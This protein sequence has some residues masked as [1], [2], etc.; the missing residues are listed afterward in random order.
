[1]R[2]FLG[3]A[4]LIYV[5]A[6][7]PVNASENT[8]PAP[9]HSLVVKG[10]QRYGS[11]EILKAS[12][13]RTGERVG[14]A[15]FEQARQAL[16]DLQVFSS[17]SDRYHYSALPPAYDVSFEVKEIEQVFPIRFERLPVSTSQITE[18][19]KANVP[20]YTDEIPGTEAVLDRYR[21]AV[22]L[23]VAHT[24]PSLKIKAIVSNEDPK[25]LAVVFGPDTPVPVISQV[26]IT[27]NAGVDS[28]SLLRAVNSVAIGVPASDVR[29]KEIL[30]GAVKHLYAESGYMDV[31]F[32]SIETEPSKTDKGVILKL[33]INE[34]PQF[35]FGSIR[36]KGSGLEED[37]V[38]A[39][40]K[41]RPGQTYDDRA[42]DD[43]RIDIQHR[44][45]RKGY[46][47]AS[48]TDE[49]HADK[50]AHVVNVAYN[51]A[52]GDVYNFAKLE[53]KG[54]DITSEPVVE[55]MWG[56]K[57]GKPFNPDYPD[58]F[59]KRIEEEKLF[60]HL[61]DTTSDYVADS[62]THSVTVKLYFHGGKSKEELQR[63]KKEEEERKQPTGDLS[64]F[65][66]PVSNY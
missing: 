45:R 55:Q 16:I 66:L 32:P 37:E 9:L 38:R 13:L 58:F 28:G 50:A 26:K 14:P 40:V 47:D 7:L 33:A 30:N 65:F 22:Q 41:F 23:F 5:C 6:A 60:E 62:S 46:L 1:M 54:L 42:V 4:T 64:P 3:A 57:P 10:N 12:G 48:V 44:L 43:L 52:P 20:L 59:L 31:T 27:G 36:F 34:G 17:V 53:I 8:S 49:I 15:D 61:A 21:K 18:Y 29:I 56:E 25:Q 2:L 11:A 51:V 19:L 24:N 63:E 39:A 35:K